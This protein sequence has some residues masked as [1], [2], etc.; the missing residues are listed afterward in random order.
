MNS[1]KLYDLK[2]K[3]DQTTNVNEKEILSGLFTNELDKL[4]AID[5]KN[6]T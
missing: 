4:S 6:R 3:F 1:G 5:G 2:T